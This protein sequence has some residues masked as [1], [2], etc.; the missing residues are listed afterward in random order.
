MKKTRIFFA[1]SGLVLAV[2][3]AFSTKASSSKFVQTTWYTNGGST[4]C[5]KYTA[6][7]CSGGTN[8]CKTALNVKTLSTSQDG[9]R[10]CATK[11]MLH[12]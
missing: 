7:N 8:A 4:S 1:V 11:L 12:Q 5:V 10:N 3:S 9:G 2:A 6:I